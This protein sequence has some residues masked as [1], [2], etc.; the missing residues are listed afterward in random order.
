MTV[1]KVTADMK[2]VVMKS[3]GG[4]RKEIARMKK[5]RSDAKLMESPVPYVENI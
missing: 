2:T 1:R 4:E 5:A 3:D